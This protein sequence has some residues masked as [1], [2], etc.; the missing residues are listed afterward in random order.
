MFWSDATQ[1]TSFGNAKL[2]PCYLFF[3]NKSK[4]RRCRPSCNLCCHVA[5]FEDA[6]ILFFELF[7]GWQIL[8]LDCWWIQGFCNPSHW[9]KNQSQQR[10]L[11]PLLSWF[12]PQAT[13]DSIQWW[14]HT[15]LWTWNS[16]QMLRWQVKM[17]LSSTFHTFHQ[18][19]RKVSTT[20][21]NIINANL[22]FF[23][24]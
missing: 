19:P 7:C 21:F 17:I 2:W 20:S 11:Y 3:G 12:F 23:I 5:Y 13:E 9:W 10:I 15:C 8:Y 24:E 22:L 16:D 1:L 4:Y 14:I 18:L 6:S